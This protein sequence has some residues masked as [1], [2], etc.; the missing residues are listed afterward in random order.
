MLEDNVR[1]MEELMRVVVTTIFEHADALPLDIKRLLTTVRE[2]V[3]W[4]LPVIPP[5]HII[6][7][8]G[9]ALP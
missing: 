1:N 3:G 2:Q 7:S 5:A 8:G 9:G 4:S 6:A